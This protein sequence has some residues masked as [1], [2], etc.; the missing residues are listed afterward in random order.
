MD[1][2]SKLPKKITDLLNKKAE[3]IAKE[4]KFTIRKSKITPSGFILA[5]IGSSF[6]SSSSLDVVCSFLKESGIYVKKQAVHER[7]NEKTKLFVQELAQHFLKHFCTNKLSNL[8]SLEI[9]SH[10]NIIDSSHIKL[11]ALLHKAFKGSGGAA[12]S[13][14]LK[15]Q[16]M[17]D[18][19]EGRLKEL[20]LTSGCTNDQG[21]DKYFDN[22]EKGA[23]YLMDLG[24]FKFQSLQ[25]I[26]AGEAFFVSRIKPYVTFFTLDGTKINLIETLSSSGARFSQKLL[27]GS[28]KI[29]VRLVANRLHKKVARKRQEKVK[30]EHERRNMK[31]TEET[32][33]LQNWSIYITNASEEQISDDAL[34]KVYAL[35]WQ[36]ELLFKLSKSLMRVNVINSKH[37]NRII[38]EI[39]SKFIAIMLLFILC[40]PVRSLYG[41]TVSFYKSCKI[42]MNKASYL[43]EALKSTYKLKKFM[44]SFFEDILFFAQK[45]IKNKKTQSIFATG[46]C[47][48][49]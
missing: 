28:N 15:V 20:E 40:T 39:Y 48:V 8:F 42:L 47:F 46:D 32:I 13:A 41:D 23:L 2:L 3:Q 44:S 9:F 38:I 34:H 16:V 22:I 27:M 49:S 14:A 43:I 31:I 6:A 12:P 4:T 37:P 24:Y 30:K 5:L 7:F 36:I 19:L 25:K 33:N 1:T 26:I 11:P 18:Y 10:I 17:F 35:R 29:P 45:D 21:F